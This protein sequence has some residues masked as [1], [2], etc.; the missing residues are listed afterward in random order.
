[1]VA[2]RKAKAA[3]KRLGHQ[4]GHTPGIVA[5]RN[6][7]LVRPDQFLPILLDRHVCTHRLARLGLALH[8]PGRIVRTGTV[9]SG[10][11][12]GRIVLPPGQSLRHTRRRFLGRQPLCGIGVTSRIEVM[13]K[14][15][16]CNAR[17]ALS[18]PEPGPDT[19][20]SSVRMPC[21][22]AFLAASSLAT[23]EIG[24]A[25]CRERG[26]IWVL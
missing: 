2:E 20:T 24:R 7:Q 12:G 5:R 25:S 3:L 23:C 10:G 26:E 14:P 19:S 22:C 6:L 18:R 17:S 4:R 9:R 15:A 13:V 1:R 11:G 8:F 16:A 21:S